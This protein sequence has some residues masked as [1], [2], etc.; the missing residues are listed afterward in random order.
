MTDLLPARP[1]P[2]HALLRSTVAVLFLLPLAHTLVLVHWAGVDVPYQESWELAPVVERALDG[3]VRPADLWLQNNEHRP[4][5]PRAAM[6][7]LAV[8]TGWNARAEMFVSLACACATLGLLGLLLVRTGRAFQVPHA[9]LALPA[10][11]AALLS[12]AQWQNWLWGWQLTLLLAQVTSVL[13]LVCLGR[14]A[15]RGGS[16]WFGG[17]I[18]AAA[19]ATFC[20]ASGAGTWPAGALLLYLGAPA[21]PERRRRLLVWLLGAT[22]CLSAY[23]VGFVPST[24]S[25]LAR[26]EDAPRV[27]IYLLC[28]LGVPTAFG[29]FAG[30][31]GAAIVGAA[32]LVVVGASARRA[33]LEP[34][35]ERRAALAT[36]CALA[37]WAVFA[38]AMCALGRVRQGGVEGVFEASRYLAFST[39]FTCAVVGLLVPWTRPTAPARRRR[40]AWAGIA[41]VGLASA[42][43]GVRFQEVAVRWRRVFRARVARVQQGDLSPLHDLYYYRSPEETAELLEVL[44]RRRL[45]LLR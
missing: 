1:R 7:G 26:P 22:A 31:L 29:A 44:R 21:G 17:A 28:F 38:G 15:D 43:A 8:V 19:A 4:V 16:T 5:L 34:R 11:S 42:A 3:Q 40:A 20:V 32:G 13:A 24:Y 37:A 6:L 41:L 35:P 2:S 39:V 23:T 10:L 14:S 33:R 45:S 27:V 18:A 36:W 25:D 30:A 9:A 12:F